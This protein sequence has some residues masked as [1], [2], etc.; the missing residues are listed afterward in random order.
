MSPGSSV[1]WRSTP[2]SKSLISW[3]L[4]K[5]TCF[6]LG[7]HALPNR[8]FRMG[9]HRAESVAHTLRLAGS[10]RE[11]DL[12]DYRVSGPTFWRWHDEE[13]LLGGAFAYGPCCGCCTGYSGTYS[14]QN[15]Q[16]ELITLT[17]RQDAQGALS[18]SMSGNNQQY[19]LE[20]ILEEGIAVGAIF[21]E[22]GGVFF[23]AQLQDAELLLT[24]IE[25]GPDNEPDY[26]KMQD[27]VLTRQ[28]A[29][30][31]A[32]PQRRK[33]AQGANPLAAAGGQ[34]DPFTGNFTGNDIS[35]QLQAGQ[36]GYTGSLT[37]Q[38][39]S[40]PV[41]ALAQGTQLQGAFTAGGQQ[42]TFQAAVQ[43][44]S[45]TLVSGGNTHQLTRQGV[46]PS[47]ANPLAQ[48]GAAPAPPTAAPAGGSGLLGRWSCQTPEGPA[49]L[50]FA[51][52]GQL[53]Y[54][55]E[56]V[57]YEIAGN[58]L[59]VP[60]DWGPVEYRF[61]LQGDRLTIQNPDAST[62]QC[63]RQQGGGQTEG[64]VGGGTGMEGH[65]L[66]LLCSYSSSPDGGYSTQHL[67]QFNGH[68]RFWYGV[69]TAWD[70]PA[71]TGVS[72]NWDN[73]EN[74]GSYQVTGTSRGAAVYL[75]FADGQTGTARVYHVYQGSEITELFLE[76]PD[77]HYAKSLCP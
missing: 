27:L 46:A 13:G 45:M 74:V 50:N 54:N 61:Q 35:L 69:E 64:A 66:G 2:P 36:G 5:I 77:R 51:S 52:A 34:G 4:R 19:Q 21:N 44:M 33:P 29:V 38:G 58:V 60:G 28:G 22:Q 41:Q 1:I 31:G 39:Q 55:G 59:R 10:C 67:L 62:S 25:P 73:G 15:Q 71:T 43:G 11:A 20:G 63:Q 49:Q 47:S 42:Y 32:E 30:A 8:G 23:E 48:Q 72:R 26:S 53:V 75:R 16:G 18:G 57:P 17:V 56:T 37:F 9:T 40:F 76:G 24:L 7:N 68:G 3:S 14:L 65:L 12:G 70:I 6:R